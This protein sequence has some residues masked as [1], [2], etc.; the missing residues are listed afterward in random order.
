MISIILFVTSCTFCSSKYGIYE[1]NCG[2]D[3]VT[4]SWGHD[5]MTVLYFYLLTSVF[6]VPL[7]LSVHMQTKPKYKQCFIAVLFVMVSNV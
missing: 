5:G 2:L 7:L 1:P 3:K 4:M 6:I